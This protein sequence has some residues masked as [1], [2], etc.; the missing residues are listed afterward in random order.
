METS[1][2]CIYIQSPYSIDFTNTPGIQS[3]L[4]FDSN[5]LDNGIDH[6]KQ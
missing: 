1:Y 4:R 6:H 5:M 3:I 2:R